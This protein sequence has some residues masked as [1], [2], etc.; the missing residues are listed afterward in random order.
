[1]KGDF[2]K[3]FTKA[4][5]LEQYSVEKDNEGFGKWLAYQLGLQMM[6]TQIRKNY[7]QEQA[8]FNHKNVVDIIQKKSNQRQ[9]Y[10]KKV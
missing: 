7:G 6:W 1:M 9:I 5:F 4:E 8:I 2:S 3:L 10:S